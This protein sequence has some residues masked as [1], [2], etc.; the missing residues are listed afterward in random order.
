MD[1]ASSLSAISLSVFLFFNL[2]QLREV[3]ASIHTYE[4][5][6]FKEVGNANLLSG[7]SEGIVASQPTGDGSKR[8]FIKWAIADSESFSGFLIR[9]KLTV[10]LSL[11]ACSNQFRSGI[12]HWLCCLRCAIDPVN[13]WIF[14]FCMLAVLKILVVCCLREFFVGAE[15]LNRKLLVFVL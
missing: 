8:S 10:D 7:G 12:W 2:L 14:R 15:L 9:W 3:D 4:L 6:S 11:I 1:L 13:E 5:E